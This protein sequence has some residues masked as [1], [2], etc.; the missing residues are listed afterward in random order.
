[1]LVSRPS[2]SVPVWVDRQVPTLLRDIA[3]ALSLRRKEV[4][5]A[6]SFTL[7]IQATEQRQ[8]SGANASCYTYRVHYIRSKIISV[9]TA[10][11]HSACL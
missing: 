6:C 7:S 4:E 1:M 8:P 11:R 10:Y 2:V 5:R 3:L 9:Y